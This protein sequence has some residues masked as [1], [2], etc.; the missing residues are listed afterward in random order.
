MAFYQRGKASI[1]SRYIEVT[2]QPQSKRH[3]VRRTDQAELIQKPQS[4]LR[5]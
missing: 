4:L 3:V 5:V 1:E 2:L